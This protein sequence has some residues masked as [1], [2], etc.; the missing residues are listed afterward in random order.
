[1]KW[2]FLNSS[3]RHGH[4]ATSLFLAENMA[5]VTSTFLAV[6]RVCSRYSLSPQF[7][8]LLLIVFEKADIDLYRDF[9]SHYYLFLPPWKLII[10]EIT[11]SVNELWTL[12]DRREYVM[13]A[14]PQRFL[15]KKK[16]V[17]LRL[18]VATDIAQLLEH[19]KEREVE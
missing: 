18:R 12:R 9:L 5:I 7:T 6:A 13:F 1:M 10:N 8:K 16:I 3:E 2:P 14:F 15:T 19:R 17:S 4:K 11:K